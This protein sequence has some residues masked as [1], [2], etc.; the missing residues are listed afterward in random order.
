M[1]VFLE[2]FFQGLGVSATLNPYT[3]PFGEVEGFYLAVALF[4]LRY[5]RFSYS[6]SCEGDVVTFPIIYS[7]E[8]LQHDTGR[9]HPEKAGRLTASVEALRQAAF[10]E[11]LSWQT[12]TAWQEREVLPW[13]LRVHRQPYVE[14]VR[15]LAEAGGGR[16][17]SDT[18]VSSQSYEVALLAVSA[19]LDGV[20]QVLR[21]GEPAFVLA[22]PPGHHA[23]PE[24]GMGFCIFANAAVAALYALSQP[25]IQRVAILD[26]DVHHGNGTQEIVWD[27]PQIAY[28]STHQAPFYPGTG[29]AEER[30]AHN[31]ILNLPMASGSTLAE[32]QPAF[33]QKILPFLREFSPD[34]LIVSAGFDANRDD[35]LASLALQPSDY[36]LFTELCLGLTRKIVFGLE[37]GYDFRALAQSVVAVVE[38]CLQPIKQRV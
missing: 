37:G 9:L 22:R 27:M 24:I 2:S 14:A 25:G 1:V 7:E 33:E 18:F 5:L 13:V 29:Q 34:L 8:F 35:P 23:L 15:R 6:E 11:Q 30:G 26:W 12:P 19:W 32:Y 3:S 36:G 38:S 16:I 20:D 4:G 10:A 31:N 28:V 21:S 17:D